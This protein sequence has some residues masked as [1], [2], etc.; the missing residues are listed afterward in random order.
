MNIMFVRSGEE[1]VEAEK[2]S[3]PWHNPLSPRTFDQIQHDWF[4]RRYISAYSSRDPLAVETARSISGRTPVRHDKL[5]H[6]EHVRMSLADANKFGPIIDQIVLGYSLIT[7]II[8]D[9]NRLT[10]EQD[11]TVVVASDSPY[12]LIAMGWSVLNLSI[13]LVKVTWFKDPLTWNRDDR[14]NN[15]TL[16]P[17]EGFMIKTHDQPLDGLMDLEIHKHS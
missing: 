4:A 9:Y 7:D 6:E 12:T 8:V 3:H 17:L 14:L 2:L 1:G 13:P 5:G 10:S 16:Q 11:E 15:L